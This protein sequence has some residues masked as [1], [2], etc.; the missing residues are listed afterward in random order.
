MH[1]AVKKGSALF[2]DCPITYTKASAIF[3]LS[4]LLQRF[5]SLG[6]WGTGRSW[7][8]VAGK[9]LQAR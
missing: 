9:D 1:A 3:F 7:S 4:L 2:L 8:Q 5:G 6:K